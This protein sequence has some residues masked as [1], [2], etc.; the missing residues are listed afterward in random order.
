MSIEANINKSRDSEGNLVT[1]IDEYRCTDS[2]SV[3]A[4]DLAP[5]A[6]GLEMFTIA[7]NEEIY[8]T[9]IY[10]ANTAANL[11]TI[12]IYDGLVTSAVLIWSGTLAASVGATIDISNIVMKAC[13]D[14]AGIFI[15][16]TNTSA[17][18]VTVN[19]KRIKVFTE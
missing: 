3:A 7:T 14:T 2:Y 12:Q 9:R 5:T 8:I 18:D 19:V 10:M 15:V 4:T 13:T 16:S 17:I 1:P 11:E 6:A